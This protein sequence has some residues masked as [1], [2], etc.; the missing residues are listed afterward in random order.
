MSDPNDTPPVA[1]ES[2]PAPAANATVQPKPRPRIWR[3]LAVVLLTVAI[4]IFAAPSV[5]HSWHTVSTDDAYVNSHVTFVAP[6][7]IGQVT[8]VLVDDNNRVKKGD[9]L[10]E[11]DPEPYQ[12]QVAIKHAAVDAAQAEVVVAQATVRSD[13]GQLRGLRFKLEHAIEDVH[14]QTAIIRARVAT[15]EQ[16]KASLAL[17]GTEFERAKQLL[18]TKA[19]SIE[20]F[21]RKK[22]ALDVANASVT[23]ALEN[24]YQARVAL[25]LAAQ[26][27]DGAKL[28]DVPDNLDQTFSSVRQALGELMQ[29]A[30]KLGVESSSFDMTPKK[31]VEEFLRRDPG[32]DVDHIYAEIIKEA[33]D[34]K[35]AQVKLE[36]ARRDLDQANLDLRYCTIRAEIDG[37]VTR[38]NVNP[39]N[40]VQ[41]GQSLMAVRSL[42][43]IW[44]DANFKETQLR[45]LRIGQ[46]VELKVDMYGSRQTFEGRVSGF[47]MGTG[48]TLALLPPQNATGNFV[49][50]VQRLP[51][52]IDIVNYDAEKVPLFV[53]LSV[54]PSVDVKSTPTG[55]SAGKFLQEVIQ[56]AP[57]SVP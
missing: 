6:R 41:V 18:P 28:T 34:L 13:V 19:I 47:T 5:I 1:K 3:K 17:A 50:V 25:G 15:W 20:E 48:S 7:V 11:L 36:Q 26:P 16:G 45:D 38:R 37:V 21:D 39:G 55:P 30:A 32:G 42:Q 35:R 24:V 33:P 51:V 43:E 10:I 8:R 12:V 53:G 31:V 46:R 54:E 27:P 2:P 22:E 14:N 4:L 57:S 40:H 52:R 49:K 44:V 29:G 56:S 23:Q 9:V